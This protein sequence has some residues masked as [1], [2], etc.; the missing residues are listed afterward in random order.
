[1]QDSG[2]LKEIGALETPVV[3]IVFNRPDLAR[4][5]LT[6]ISQVKPKRLFVISDGP[7]NNFKDD[8]EL[9]KE[10]RSLIS[11][12][13][14]ECEVSVLEQATN[15]GCQKNI[16]SGLNWVFSQVQ[17]AI[18]L[19]DDCV[20]SQ[21]FFFYC[22]NLL[23]KYRDNTDVGCISGA[24][25]DGEIGF[26]DS[27]TFKFSKFPSVWGWATWKRVWDDVPFDL[28]NLTYRQMYLRLK[29]HLQSPGGIRYFFA[30]LF[31]IKRGAL[32]TWDYQFV[33]SFWER[34]LVSVIPRNNLVSNVGFGSRSTHTVRGKSKYFGM[35]AVQSGFPFISPDSTVPSRENEIEVERTRFSSSFIRTAAELAFAIAPRSVRN[36]TLRVMRNMANSQKDI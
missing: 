18:I 19:E 11:E 28:S 20:P 10:C 12:I 3:L 32:D 26:I 6:E 36:V 27:E 22:S 25:L 7:R 21:E 14:W 29:N 16:V 33:L 31:M 34:G 2:K 17:E 23:A 15:V 30:K 1:M 9:V 13:D 8:A 5:V 35:R 24:N 4:L